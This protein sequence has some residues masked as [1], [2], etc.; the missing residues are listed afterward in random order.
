[1][2]SSFD[3]ATSEFVRPFNDY[4]S[5]HVMQNEKGSVP[6]STNKTYEKTKIKRLR[7]Q[8]TTA[9]LLSLWY[10]WWFGM[11]MSLSFYTGIYTAQNH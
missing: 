1:M 7:Y 2:H 8:E 6:H 4:M 5:L 11:S 10:A 3:Q 9:W